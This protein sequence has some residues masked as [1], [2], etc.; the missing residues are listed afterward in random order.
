MIDIL[1]PD[2]EINE[3]CPHNHAFICSSTISSNGTKLFF[4]HFTGK[5]VDFQEE[6]QCIEAWPGMA[7]SSNFQIPSSH[8]NFVNKKFHIIDWILAALLELCHA[9]IGGEKK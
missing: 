5:V 6:H 4:I 9:I 3:R 7:T 1:H 8:S 2:H